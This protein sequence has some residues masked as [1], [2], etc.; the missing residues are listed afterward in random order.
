MVTPLTYEGLLDET[1]KI[2]NC[3]IE[4]DANLIA[5]PQSSS[6]GASTPPVTGSKKKLLVNSSDTV[7]AFVRNLNFRSIGSL[8]AKKLNYVNETFEARHEAIGGSVSEM[9]EYMQKF[10][11]AHV[12]RQFLSVHVNIAD[13]ISQ[14]TLKSK[15]FDRRLEIEKSMLEQDHYDECEDY[16][17]HCI[18]KQEN[19]FVVL[20]LILLFSYTNG[21][22]P[23]KLEQ[24]KREMVQTYG[25][26]ILF[27]LNNLEKLGFF[28]F[29]K[30][31]WTAINKLL[32]CTSSN[33]ASYMKGSQIVD[34][35]YVC[36]GYAPL[37]VRLLEV[38][39]KTNWK[40][41]EDLWNYFP[42]QLFEVRQDVVFPSK[43]RASPPPDMITSQTPLSSTSNLPLG[44]AQPPAQ[45][46]NF[47]AEDDDEFEDEKRKPICLVFFI[48]GVTYA[49]IA[50][51]RW[52]S[53][54]PS[55]PC[56]YVIA[57]T[58][59]VN[60]ESFLTSLQEDIKRL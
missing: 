3:T 51:L 10:K 9:R 21:F 31:H 26:K 58:C 33:G 15:I 56:E 43:N 57:S 16:I 40:R 53:A 29:R 20:K 6:A 1:F 50:A 7:F 28:N 27:I 45:S 37:S 48:G 55:H 36:E 42:G 25:F 34:A 52:L 14:V 11:T 60:P 35:A 23:K 49:E 18:A 41:M 4:V 54:Q 30:S 59:I 44:E 12:E 13:Y 22:R 47:D 39:A 5:A 38:A 32:N 2:S 8:L 19:V 17:E 46:D 24:W